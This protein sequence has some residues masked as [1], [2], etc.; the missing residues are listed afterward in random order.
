MTRSLHIE[1]SKALDDNPGQW[2]AYESE[3]NCVV[4]AGPGSGKTKTLTIK[5][6]RMLVEDV[7]VPRGIACITYSNECARELRCRLK[8]LGVSFTKNV[9]V[10]TI[11]SFCLTN[12]VIPYAHLA[13]LEL[14]QPIAIARTE[15]RDR[16]FED[17]FAEVYSADVNPRDFRLNV[18]NYRKE[19]LDR[20]SADW[21]RNEEYAQVIQR[22]ESRLRQAGLIDF[23]DMVLL[24]LRLV[25]EN[26]WVRK[27]LHARFPILVVDEYQDLGAPLHRIVQHLCFQAGIRLFAVGDPDQSIYGFQGA[28][29]ELL[30]ELC[31]DNRIEETVRLDFNYRCGQTIIDASEAALGEERNYESRSSAK[32]EVFFY[33]CE[34][35]VDHQAEMVC[36]TIVPAI[37]ERLGCSLGDVAIV[38]CTKYDG[39]NVAVAASEAGFDFVRIDSGAPYRKTPL[40]RWLEDCASWCAGGWRKGKPALSELLGTWLGFANHAF[41]DSDIHEQKVLLAKFLFEHRDPNTRLPDWLSE[42]HESCLEE[43]LQQ[44]LTMPDNRESFEALR[45]ACGDELASMPLAAFGGQSG[46]PEHLNLITMHSAKG[47]EFDAVVMFN[48]DQDTIPGW[49]D[50]TDKQKLEKRRQFYVG[51]TR[52]KHEVHMTYT[53]WSKTKTG[54]IVKNGP[55]E[56]LLEVQE[57]VRPT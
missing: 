54:R 31:D 33:H 38:Y 46:S 24:G 26:A 50:L 1:A 56:F 14:P 39:G 30:K 45:K 17:A 20:A 6:A 5:M 4:L 49:R 7:A 10:G 15:V 9:Y 23:D 34:N 36:A 44:E 53:G 11:H 16:L 37:M 32:G 35:G 27:V 12:I 47:L 22:Y 52:A 18:E 21:H 51:L 41:S 43:I 2:Q 3:S 42:F 55:S 19:H 8:D 40:T 57:R 13:G 25:K 28:H 48:M 29:P